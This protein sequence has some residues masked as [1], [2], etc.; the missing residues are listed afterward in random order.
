MLHRCLGC[1]L[2]VCSL[3]FAEQLAQISKHDVNFPDK[4]PATVKGF[5]KVS[6]GTASEQF[7]DDDESDGE[8]AAESDGEVVEEAF[9]RMMGKAPPL[10]EVRRPIQPDLR[11]LW[12]LCAS[13]G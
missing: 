12:R 10:D 3:Q 9:L 1:V 7:G 6:I 13:A 2:V 11:C 4:C 8:V 5:V